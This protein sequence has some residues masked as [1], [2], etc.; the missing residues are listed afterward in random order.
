MGKQ[1][2]H[3]LKHSTGVAN[4]LLVIL[5]LITVLAS[6]TLSLAILDP[7]VIG[8]VLRHLDPGVIGAIPHHPRLSCQ[9]IV[10]HVDI[11]IDIS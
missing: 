8:A 6:S 3:T 4:S 11:S 9:D 1:R 5:I 7:G 10:V 2:N